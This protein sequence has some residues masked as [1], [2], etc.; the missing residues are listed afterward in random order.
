MTD[1][2]LDY[3]IGQQVF[4]NGPHGACFSEIEEIDAN[5]TYDSTNFRYQL[6]DRVEL[7]ENTI[8]RGPA[9]LIKFY[10][11]QISDLKEE[12]DND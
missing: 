6:R 4:Y 1:I 10:E 11:R 7:D 9:E 5:I 2:D 12:A 8:F 3:Q